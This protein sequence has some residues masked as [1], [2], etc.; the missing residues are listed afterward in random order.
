MQVLFKSFYSI[1]L[2]KAD[3]IPDY[4]VVGVEQRFRLIRTNIFSSSL[5]D[6]LQKVIQDGLQDFINSGRGEKRAVG[7]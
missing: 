4:I 2:N 7:W 1:K 6:L 3:Y 5:E